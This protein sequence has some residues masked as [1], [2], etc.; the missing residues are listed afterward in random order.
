MLDQPLITGNGSITILGVVRTCLTPPT[1]RVHSSYQTLP[2]FPIW[3][4]LR[5]C[6]ISS[7]WRLCQGTDPCSPA[8]WWRSP[9]CPSR[10][11]R[12]LCWRTL[13]PVG[14]V[15][16]SELHKGDGEHRRTQNKCKTRIHNVQNAYMM[17]KMHT[18]CTKCIH[19]VHEYDWICIIC[20]IYSLNHYHIFFWLQKWS[21]VQMGSSNCSDNVSGMLDLWISIFKV[22]G[23]DC[24]WQIHANSLEHVFESFWL[25][26]RD[27]SKMHNFSWIYIAFINGNRN[28]VISISKLFVWLVWLAWYNTIFLKFFPCTGTKETNTS[29]L[30][31]KPLNELVLGRSSRETMPNHGTMEELCEAA[32]GAT[33]TPCL[34]PLALQ[35]TGERGATA[36]LARTVSCKRLGNS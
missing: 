31:L 35:I 6:D 1:G 24:I 9:S 17:Y 10:T 36:G 18:W 21:L 25:F 26:I 4:P 15:Q 23:A 33:T 20:I 3:V 16:G 2:I 27:R 5:L 12:P 7:F 29:V 11:R 34:Q 32:S 13:R 30:L 8:S 19:D 28:D 14:L 22:C